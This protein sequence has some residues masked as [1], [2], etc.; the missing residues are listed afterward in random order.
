MMDRD[1]MFSDHLKEAESGASVEV[2]ERDQNEHGTIFTD[3]PRDPVEYWKVTMDGDAWVYPQPRR[4]GFRE[5]DPCF[6]GDATPQTIRKI[7]PATL[8]RDGSRYVLDQKGTVR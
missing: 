6:E 3:D 4:G 1:Y 5:L 7:T 8:Q 2:V